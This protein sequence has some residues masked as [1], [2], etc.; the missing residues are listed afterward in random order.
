[1]DEQETKKDLITQAK[2]LGPPAGGFTLQPR[3]F[4]E[5]FRFSNLIAESDLIP[6]EFHGKPANVLVAVQLGMEM[7]V[8]PMQALQ[9]IYVVNGRPAIFGDLLPAIVFNSGLLESI[10][11]EGDEKSASCTVKRKGHDAITRTFTWEDAKRAKAFEYGK[12]ITL[13]EKQTYQSY[14]KRMLQ[15]RARSWA[16]RDGFPDVLK[17]CAVKEELDDAIETTSTREPPRE[18]ISAPQP[19][20]REPENGDQHRGEDSTPTPTRVAEAEKQRRD[21]GRQQDVGAPADAPPASGPAPSQEAKPPKEPKKVKAEAKAEEKPAETVEVETPPELTVEDRLLEWIKTCS[22]EDI[23]Q[24]INEF[25][26]SFN[27]INKERQ[28]ELLRAYNNRRQGK[29]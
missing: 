9:N 12:T 24:N 26:K 19:L 8:S 22:D 27:S 10:H 4:E 3:T 5:A 1:M 17:G 13:A 28:I 25:T 15:M 7:G 18:Q 11:E 20:R 2:S 29:A 6:K 16:I 21:G 14:P 23:G